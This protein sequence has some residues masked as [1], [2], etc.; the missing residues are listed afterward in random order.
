MIGSTGYVGVDSIE[1]DQDELPNI[2]DFSNIVVDVRALDESKLKNV[3]N[4]RLDA[5]RTQLTRLLESGGRIIVLSDIKRIDQRPDKYPDT[6]NNYAWSPITI[7]ISNE[8]GDTL[9][10]KDNGFPA[11]HAQL[12]NWPYYFFVPRGCLTRDLTN[13]FG[14]THNTKYR[15]PLVPYVENRYG[16]TVSGRLTIEVTGEKTDNSGY[17]SYKFYPDIPDHITGEVILLPLIEKIDHKNAVRLVL[18]DELGKPAGYSPPSW[19]ESINVPG[20]AEAEALIN[21]SNDEIERIKS[22]VILLEEK[23][24]SIESYRKLIYSSGFDLENIVKHSF[25]ALGVKVIPAKYGQE[26]YILEYNSKEY[27]VEVKG[28]SKSISLGHL[29]QLNDYILKFEED[30]GSA[31]KGILFGNSWRA[32]PPDERGTEQKPEFPENVTSRATQWGVSLISSVSFFEAFCEFL[33]G[34]RTAENIMKKIISSSGVTS[35]E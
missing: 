2:V 16:K 25:E 6:A 31:C 13:Y 33:E 1:W 19:V 14:S 29:R 22:E 9:V 11:Y 17:N 35:F 21:S 5:L 32:I 20:A 7:G 3:S 4:E 10:F 23:L 27:L 12:H 34:R 18:E 30:T 26:E 28:V 15:V 8:S 24:T